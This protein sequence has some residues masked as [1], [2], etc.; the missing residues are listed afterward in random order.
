MKMCL[1][2]SLQRPCRGHVSKIKPCRRKARESQD[3]RS[4]MGMHC[5]MVALRG[6]HQCEI[7]AVNTGQDQNDRVWKRWV[8]IKFEISH[9]WLEE[10]AKIFRRN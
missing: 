3:K 2:T 7:L 4:C 1:I 10:F 8:R 9:S 6:K 5:S